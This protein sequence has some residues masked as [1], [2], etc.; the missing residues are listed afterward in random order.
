MR[1]I[2]LTP[3]TSEGQENHF[4]KF[5]HKMLVNSNIFRNFVPLILKEGKTCCSVATQSPPYEYEQNNY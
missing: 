5:F 4:F 3:I 2:L 1:Q